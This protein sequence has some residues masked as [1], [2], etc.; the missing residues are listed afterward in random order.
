M[1]VTYIGL[2][3]IALGVQSV[4]AAVCNCADN[5]ANCLKGCGKF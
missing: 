1:K 5:D 4:I 2:A 3:T